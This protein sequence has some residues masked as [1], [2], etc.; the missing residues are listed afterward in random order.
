M[1]LKTPRIN[2]NINTKNSYVDAIFESDTYIINIEIN[3][4]KGRVSKE[5]NL[6]YIC[7]MVLK[8]NEIGKIKKLKPITQININNYDYFNKDEFI[9]KS[10]IMEEKSHRKRDD[11]ITIIDINI[12][13][14]SKI[15]YN[16]IKKREGSLEYLL[17]VF[18]CSNIEELKE[19]YSSDKKMDKVKKKIEQ[20]TE[21]LDY[22]LYYDP[23]EIKKADFYEMG[24]EE[25]SKRRTKEI[26]MAMLKNGE[27]MDKIIKYTN[28][29][30]KEIEEL[31]N[32]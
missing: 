12:D 24:E 27:T 26:A 9:Y 1:I 13:K 4:N 32:K 3:Y 28:L 21:D 5:K 23:E 7:H 25:G 16:E 8:Q 10:Y 6:R 2:S 14:L 31:E 11:F 19:L 30:Q 15:P 18:V 17:Y 29:T 22:F 20:L